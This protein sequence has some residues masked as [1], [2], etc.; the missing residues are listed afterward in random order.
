MSMKKH[1]SADEILE[2]IE[3]TDVNTRFKLRREAPIK[4]MI[5]A[6]E[7]TKSTQARKLLCTVLGDRQ[8]KSAVPILI[9]HL[10]DSDLNVRCY[11]AESLGKIGDPKAG[12]ALLG[13]FKKK[14]PRALRSTLA[15]VMGPIHYQP[16]VPRLIRALADKDVGVRGCAAWSLGLLLPRESTPALKKALATETQQWAK[17]HMQDALD[18][19]AKTQMSQIE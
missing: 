10:N 4:E 9:Q 2:L 17:N 16:A 15:V 6:L 12:P 13:L 3:L 7:K 14:Q 19:I 5:L 18:K 1:L 8:A 11:S